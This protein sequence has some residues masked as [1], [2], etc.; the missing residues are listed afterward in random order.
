M[1]LIINWLISVYDKKLDFNFKTNSLANWSS[2][3]S[4][5][6]LKAIL[7]LQPARFKR[8]C[9]ISGSIMLDSSVDTTNKNGFP[10]NSLIAVFN[11]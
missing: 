10:P 6:V 2:C 4:N 11:R 1:L 5:K 3:I 7:F 8:I 9:N